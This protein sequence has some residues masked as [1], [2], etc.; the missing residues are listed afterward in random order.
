MQVVSEKWSASAKEEIP[1]AV[2]VTERTAGAV[3]AAAAAVAAA[4]TV[5]AAAATV[6]AIAIAA[7]AAATVIAVAATT[8]HGQKGSGKSKTISARAVVATTAG[9]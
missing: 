1:P 4:A 2:A 7:A 5:I 3:A 6:I 8:S 9:R